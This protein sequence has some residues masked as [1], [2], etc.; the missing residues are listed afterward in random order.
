MTSV[1][2]RR[3]AQHY[4]ELYGQVLC[5][6]FVI[7]KTGAKLVEIINFSVELDPTQKFLEFPGRKTPVKYVDDE[8]KWYDS[9]DLSVDF[10]GQKAQIWKDASSSEGKINSNY[11]WMIYSPDNYSQYSH[12]LEELQHNR[13]SRRAVMIYQR[14]SMQVDYN[15]KG[16]SDFCC[17][18]G[19][20]CFIRK[21]KLTYIVKMRSN[22]G[23]FGFF[24]DFAWHAIVYER[25]FKDLKETYPDLE[26]GSLF[27][28]AASFH[29]YERHFPMLKQMVTGESQ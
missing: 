4:T 15:Y 13:E 1:N 3:L 10:I 14:P 8:L 5:E 22:D 9:M 2:E 18:D 28:N 23:I 25:L 19:V 24:N 11:G 29:V 16:M 12:C 6:D 26:Y 21:N 7:D 20:Q 27:W 17:T